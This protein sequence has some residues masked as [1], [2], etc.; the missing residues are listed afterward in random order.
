MQ[1]RSIGVGALL[2]HYFFNESFVSYKKVQIL[3]YFFYKSS[4]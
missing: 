1:D 4:K 3:I 2:I